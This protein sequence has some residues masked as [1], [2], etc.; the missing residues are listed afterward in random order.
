MKL[1]CQ[2]GILDISTCQLPVGNDQAATA[3]LEQASQL[4]AA[5]AVSRVESEPADAAATG[6]EPAMSMV[7]VG[8]GADHG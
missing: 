6:L 5:V 8:K 4:A 1:P 2:E 3:V 7:S